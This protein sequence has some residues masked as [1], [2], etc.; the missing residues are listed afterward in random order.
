MPRRLFKPLSRQRHRWKERWFMRPFRVVLEH[1]VYWSLNRRSVT[2]AFALGLFVAFVPIPFHLLLGT[3][4]ALLLRL[5]V[6]AAI[7]G[8]FLTNPLTMVPLYVAAYWVGCHLLGVTE[9]AVAFE[10]N[11]H[12][13]TTTLLP[14]WKPFLLGCL[15]LGTLSA[16][17]GYILVGGAWHIGLVLKYHERK[18]GSAQ[19]ESAIAEKMRNEKVTGD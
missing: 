19:R 16:T 1:P 13:L 12:W 17:L 6:P 7:V 2:R 10:L 3:A 8:T 4:L 15:I 18:T 9:R 14:I 11:W 5:N